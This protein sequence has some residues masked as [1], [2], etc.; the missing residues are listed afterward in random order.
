MILSKSPA[1]TGRRVLAFGLLAAGLAVLPLRPGL[2]DDVV[3]PAADPPAVKRWDVEVFKFLDDGSQPDPRPKVKPKSAPV[4]ERA[5]PRLPSSLAPAA[6][7]AARLRDELEL[8]EAAGQT[9]AAHVRA[10]EVAVAAA[11]RQLEQLRRHPGTVAQT[12]I[13]AVQNALDSAQAQLDVRKAEMNEHAVKVKQAKRRLEAAAGD[14]PVE[15][16][17]DRKVPAADPRDR[18]P[19]AT[20]AAPNVEAMRQIRDA[21]TTTQA[22]LQDLTAKRQQLEAQLKDIS[23]QQ[24]MVVSQMERLRAAMEDVYKKYPD[25]GG[26]KKP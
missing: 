13:V 7:D 4:D 26:P 8:L 17:L 23:K 20:E 19:P 2:A 11:A 5:Y 6:A 1:R 18:K 25:A 10:A 3:V 12:E 14:R 22:V 21:L 16:R 24:E 15:M 9:K